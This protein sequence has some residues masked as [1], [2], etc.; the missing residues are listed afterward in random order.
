MSLEQ[1]FVVPWVLPHLLLCVFAAAASWAAICWWSRGSIGVK[2]VCGVF[3][4]LFS[5]FVAKTNTGKL[6]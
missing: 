3:S 4:H 5:A 6:L 1:S 2:C